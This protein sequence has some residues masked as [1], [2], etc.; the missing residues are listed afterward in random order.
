MTA[1]FS[2][3]LNVYARLLELQEGRVDYLHFGVFDHPDEPVLRAQQRASD[4]LWQALPAP[5]RVLEVGIGVGTTLARLWREGWQPLGIT[6]EAAQI[7][8]ARKRH[9]PDLPLRCA[10][11]EE[12]DA[13]AGAFDVLLFQESAQYVAPLDLFAAAER[14]LADGPAHI[15]VMDEFALTRREAAHWGLRH[16]D[17]FVA[18]A[19]RF[20]WTLDRSVDLSQAVQPTI[21]YLLDGLRRKKPDLLASLP[22]TLAQFDELDA[23]LR[24]VQ[25]LYA[26]GVQGYALLRFTRTRSPAQHPVRVEA[27]SAAEVRALFGEVFGHPMSEADW[28][29]KYGEGRGCALGLRRGGR[30]LAHYGGLRRMVWHAGERFAACQ[31]CDVIVHADLRSHLGRRNAL[32]GLTASFLESEIGWGLPHRVG[33]GFPTD[34]AFRV[35]QRLGLYEAVDTMDCASWPALRLEREL[36]VQGLQ[37]AQLRPGRVE[38]AEVDAL[39]REMR[40]ERQHDFIAERDAA[41]LRHR[42]LDHPRWRYHIAMVRSRWLRSPLG[43]VV[44]R[45]HEEHL[46]WVDWVG[47]SAS[48]P[49]LLGVLRD[50]AFR[51]GKSRVDAWITSSHRAVLQCLA[52]GVSW[53]PLEITVPANV[54]SPGPSVASLRSCW[55]LTAGDTDFR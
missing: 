19:E 50:Q 1:G 53:R 40:D 44:W 32:H 3:P 46:E 42:Y 15:V 17:H 51:A 41:W 39:W 14:L 8:V 55:W 47:C 45:E 35:A 18:L 22:V 9:G 34:R 25:Q 49:A 11:L 20:G 28:A 29:W 33:F 38:A 16:R 30:L 52:P 37:A 36:P 26:T 48:L 5:G 6:P 21:A 12:L 43:V 13:A 4:L 7:E 24:R 27:G 54:Y 23:A 31:V 10:R 2:F